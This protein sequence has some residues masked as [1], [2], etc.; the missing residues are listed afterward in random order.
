MTLAI[1]GLALVALVAAT[2]S[3]PPADTADAGKRVESFSETAPN[4]IAR[5]IAY[6]INKKLPDL[7]VR[8]RP[9]DQSIY[10]ILSRAE[11]SPEMVGVIRVEQS[12]AGSHL[13]TWLPNRSLSAA[14]TEIAQ[15]LIA[16][17]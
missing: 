4:Q 5:C 12:E 10:I 13:T 16:G 2:S 1:A 15:K 9:A 8:S 11:P 14:P 6:N 7:L 17:C 3:A